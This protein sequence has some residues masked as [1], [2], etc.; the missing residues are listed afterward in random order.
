MTLSIVIPTYN[1]EEYLPRLLSS[2]EKQSY[3]DFEMIVAD[4]HST[5]QT[6]QIAKDA[7]CRVV[8]GGL[9]GVGR[10]AGAAVAKGELVLFLDADVELHDP[11]F[12]RT[13]LST[14]KKRNLDIATVWV[15]H[16]S[17]RKI[18]EW[19][20]DFY[21]RYVTTVQRLFPHSVGF[22]IMVKREIHER[23]GGFDESIQLA[24]DHEYG[25]RAVKAGARYGVLENLQ[26]PV[27]VRRFDR[28]G[29]LSIT[30]KYVL[31][32]LHMMTIGPVR[33]DIFKYR[34]GHA[35]RRIKQRA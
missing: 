28:D 12:L 21:N 31:C 16:I 24:E 2:L 19:L 17:D 6:R 3:R 34:F 35:K 27:S 25:Q 29:Y 33:S 9:P 20:T 5:D 11:H 1:E 7:G 32:E 23:I 30:C 15:K 4:A 26:I 13:F 22:C 10:N 8:D 18:D 14:F